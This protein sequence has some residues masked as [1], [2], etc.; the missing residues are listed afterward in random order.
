ML[1]LTLI[2]PDTGE[3]ID[4][5]FPGEAIDS[6]DKAVPKAITSAYKYALL[7]LAM[8]GGGDGDDPEH[9]SNETGGTSGKDQE[10]SGKAKPVQQGATYRKPEESTGT[11]GKVAEP[12]QHPKTE[13]KPPAQ[14]PATK[15]TQSEQPKP[16]DKPL[17]TQT[18]PPPEQKPAGDSE[19]P[20]LEDTGK[21]TT[22]VPAMKGKPA[23]LSFKRSSEGGGVYQVHFDAKTVDV[24]GLLQFL[25]KKTEVKIICDIS[26]GNPYLMSVTEA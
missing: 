15:P 5:D 16:A 12:T 18:A 22:V 14:T 11:T 20:V 2:D 8:N 9:D 21:I 3:S 25:N 10:G 24:P 17:S 26:S 1:K 19:V 23:S 13:A 6:Q 4:M 7:K